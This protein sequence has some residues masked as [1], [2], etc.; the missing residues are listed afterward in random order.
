MWFHVAEYGSVVQAVV[1]VPKIHAKTFGTT[2]TACGRSA[3]G[4]RREWE[5]RSTAGL[6]GMCSWCAQVLEHLRDLALNT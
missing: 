3:D 6:D 5:L 2:T 4:M 1:A